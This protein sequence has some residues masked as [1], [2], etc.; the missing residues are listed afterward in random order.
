MSETA[1]TRTVRI[2]PKCGREYTGHPALS[3]AA[4]QRRSAPIA[5]RGRHLKALE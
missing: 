3:R 4:I 2:C 5:G 1:T